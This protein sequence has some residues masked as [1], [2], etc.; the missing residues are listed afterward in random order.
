M[1]A[2]TEIRVLDVNV[3]AE[4]I[5]NAEPHSPD[6][7]ALALAIQRAVGEEV[8]MAVHHWGL[9]KVGHGGGFWM[10]TVA[11]EFERRME[12]GFPVEPSSFRMPMAKCRGCHVHPPIQNG[13]NQEAEWEKE[14]LV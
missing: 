4:D 6:R 9:H 12:N 8:S 2:T 5:Q 14:G 7:S 13:E 10:P 1:S 11:A 3:I